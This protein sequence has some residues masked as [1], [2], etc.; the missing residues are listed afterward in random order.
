MKFTS[1]ELASVYIVE[2]HKGELWAESEGLGKGS[3]FHLKLSSKK[4]GAEVKEDP[5]R[6]KRLAKA[7]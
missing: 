3:V 5:A 6:D 4:P 2:D 7:A 1:K